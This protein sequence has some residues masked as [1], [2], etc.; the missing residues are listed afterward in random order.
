MSEFTIKSINQYSEVTSFEVDDRILL[1][2]GLNFKSIKSKNIFGFIEVR[3]TFSQTEIQNM[4]TVQ[5]ELV[6]TIGFGSNVCLVPSFGAAKLNHNGVTYTSGNSLRIKYTG[7]SDGNF[8]YGTANTLINATSD[9][10][11]RLTV[12][13]GTRTTYEEGASLTVFIN[14]ANPTGAGGTIDLYLLIKLVSF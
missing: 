10:I 2:R 12:A 9:R 13:G 7:D 14:S 6:D 4:N 3:R 5:I 8:I 11:E 1:Q